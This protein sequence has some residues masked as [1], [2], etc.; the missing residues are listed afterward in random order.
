MKEYIDHYY[1][2][3]F[4]AISRLTRLPNRDDLDKLTQNVLTDLW[5]HKDTFERETH[6]GVYIYKTILRHVFSFLRQTG[7]EQRIE[8]LQKN[9]PINP[10]HLH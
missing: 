4:A 5:E 6:Q 2:S 3:I 7:D 8:F 1:P 10:S 9:L